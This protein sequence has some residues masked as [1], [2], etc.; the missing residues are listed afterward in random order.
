MVRVPVR[1]L[2][3]KK[4]APPPSLAWLWAMTV[5]AIVTVYWSPSV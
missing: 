3:T 4:M 1:L 2:L 5:P